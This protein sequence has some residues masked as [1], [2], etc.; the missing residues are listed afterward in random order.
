[1]APG[2]RCLPLYR[3]ETGQSVYLGPVSVLVQLVRGVSL[4]G[5]GVPFKDILPILWD[6]PLLLPIQGMVMGLVFLTLMLKISILPI[7]LSVGRILPVTAGNSQA[8]LLPD[9]VRYTDGS[10]LTFWLVKKL[11]RFSSVD[12]PFTGTALL[13]IT[14]FPCLR[15]ALAHDCCSSE[16]DV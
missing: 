1:M 8:G 11:D 6:N 4:I 14:D 7:Q 9:S 15:R 13:V 12:G 10:F 2:F 5:R 3:L 16:Y